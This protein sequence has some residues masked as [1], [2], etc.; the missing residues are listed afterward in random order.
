MMKAIMIWD[1]R[2]DGELM[3]RTGRPAKWS[4]KDLASG[5][6]VPL[7]PALATDHAPP[8]TG[9]KEAALFDPATGQWSVVPDHRG[10]IHYD[11]ATGEALHVECLGEVPD[12]TE[13]PAADLVAPYWDGEKWTEGAAEETVIKTHEE[14]VLN[15]RLKVQAADGL[16]IKADLETELAKA[17]AKLN[18]VKS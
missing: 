18:K 9:K 3:S 2:P 14:M 16:T 15:L 7:I 6:Y 4:P 10:T 13:P 17:E 8:E 1:Y 5:K 11:P 12:V